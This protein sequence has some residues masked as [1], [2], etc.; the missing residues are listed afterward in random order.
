M[1]CVFCINFFTLFLLIKVWKTIKTENK[2]KYSHRIWFCWAL[3]WMRVLS[4]TEWC[5][6]FYFAS[7]S[8]FERIFYTCVAIANYGKIQ[9]K[10]TLPANIHIQTHTNSKY[11]FVRHLMVLTPYFISSFCLFS[12]VLV[13]VHADSDSP[14][15]CLIFF[16]S[17]L[18]SF[19]VRFLLKIFELCVGGWFFLCCMCFFT[20][21]IFFSSIHISHTPQSFYG[22]SFVLK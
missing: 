3:Q 8:R 15:C 9:K 13:C 7:H 2:D 19:S 12:M 21:I 5:V 10:C 16:S 18:L 17:L 11:F 6:F 20:L 22:T 4:S 14:R 1:F